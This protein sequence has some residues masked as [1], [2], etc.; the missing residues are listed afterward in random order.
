M[1]SGTTGYV[2]GTFVWTDYAYDDHGAN[3]DGAPGGDVAYPE[4]ARNTADLIQMQIDDHGA[5][6]TVR[7]ILETLKEGLLPV[8]EVGFDTVAD[9]VETVD[10]RLVLSED[11]LAGGHLLRLLDGVWDE[12]GTFGVVFDEDRLT[13]D[14]SIP[15]ALLDPG[16]NT[17]PTVASVAQREG[18]VMDLAFVV[19]PI[20]SGWQD[21]A[22]ADKLA[23]AEPAFEEV[24]FGKIAD[25]VHEPASTPTQA[26]LYSFIY[27]SRVR[28]RGGVEEGTSQVPTLPVFTYLGPYQ[29]YGVYVPEELPV[30]PPVIVWMHGSTQNHVNGMGVWGPRGDRPAADAFSQVFIGPGQFEVPAVV[31]AP[32][33]RGEDYVLR[34]IGE[35]DVLDAL[36]DAVA[37]YDADA[38]RIVLSGASLGGYGTTDLAV[39]HPERW[40][41]AFAMLGTTNTYG[42]SGPPDTSRPLWPN[43]RNIPFR[44]ADG[45]ADVAIAVGLDSEQLAAYLDERHYDYGLW[46]LTR[47]H[48]EVVPDIMNCLYVK[49]LDHVRDPNPAHVTLAVDPS[50]FLVDEG[51]ASTMCTTTPTGCPTSSW[52]TPVLASSTRS[53]WRA[54]TGHRRSRDSR[55]PSART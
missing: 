35:Q 13:V 6:I 2:H 25:G 33:G 47:R 9:G 20:F 40:S 21:T 27:H 31:V 37:R 46:L 12:T 17:W 39:R 24:D 22:Q 30:S 18:D 28:L 7:A 43:L 52:P 32:L 34:D 15:H 38:N 54:A 49:A 8:V 26:G 45:R 51:A 4:G 19:E 16:R 53:P 11:G 5:D 10:T 48:H 44:M 42:T 14:A 29:P 41:A 3:T 36:D 23:A 55:S 1:V 50:T